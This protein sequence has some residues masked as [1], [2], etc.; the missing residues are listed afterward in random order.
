MARLRRV[1]ELRPEH[2]SRTS[3]LRP[4]SGATSHYVTVGLGGTAVAAH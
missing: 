1:G 3:P 2:M 4:S